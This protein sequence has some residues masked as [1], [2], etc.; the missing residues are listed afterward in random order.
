MLS[1]VRLERSRGF[2]RVELLRVE[3]LIGEHAAKLLREWH[4]YFGD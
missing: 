1:T 4:E 2:G 3:R